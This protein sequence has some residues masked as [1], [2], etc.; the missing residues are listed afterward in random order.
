[1]RFKFCGINFKISFLFTVYLALIT[2][3]DK[4]GEILYFF[5]S[6]AIHESAHLLTMCFLKSKPKAIL[7]IPGGINIVGKHTAS[8]FDDLLILLS[9]PVSNLICY[10][11]FTGIFSSA[12]LL[13]FVY[14]ILPIN[15]LDGGSILKILLTFIF[16]DS[17][18][19]II[20]SILTIVF[21]SVLL[22]IFI[23]FFGVNEYY[24]IMIYS[25]YMIS[26]LVL[27]KW[28]KE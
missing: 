10:F 20:L 7:L 2:V 5:T 15:G 9:G 12:S 24:S 3:M 25:V 11:A 13:L 26:L 1:M 17:A 18:S 4:T 6:A 19:K 8:S 21:Y 27:K 23:H 22:I 14:N 16:N 28:L